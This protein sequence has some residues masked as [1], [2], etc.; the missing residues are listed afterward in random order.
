MKQMAIIFRSC[1]NNHDAQRQLFHNMSLAEFRFLIFSC[2]LQQP[3]VPREGTDRI[4]FCWMG[5][6][7]PGRLGNGSSQ[8]YSSEES[9]GQ[10]HQGAEC[11]P[12]SICQRYNSLYH[13]SASAHNLLAH[14]IHMISFLPNKHLGLPVLCLSLSFTKSPDNQLPL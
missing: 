10:F 6:W 14:E 1:C 11:L 3:S 7:G 12:V 13:I 4:S 8:G 2:Q 9:P 5:S